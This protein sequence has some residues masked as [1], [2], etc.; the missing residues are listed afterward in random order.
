MFEPKIILLFSSCIFLGLWSGCR[1]PAPADVQ[2]PPPPPEDLVQVPVV[3]L[4]ADPVEETP[5]EKPGEPSISDGITMKLKGKIVDFS[6][7]ATVPDPE[8]RTVKVMAKPTIPY[9]DVA[10]VLDRLHEMGFLISFVS[11]D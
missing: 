3:P 6:I 2:M 9:E 1:T 11:Q 7:L 8:N 5:P 4:S 10:A